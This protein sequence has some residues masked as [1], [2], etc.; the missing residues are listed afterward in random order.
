MLSGVK[1]RNNE[2]RGNIICTSELN[3]NAHTQNINN[4]IRI[5]VIKKCLSGFF[6]WGFYEIQLLYC[7][8]MWNESQF[9]FD[10]PE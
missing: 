8:N 2:R 7:N 9:V 6:L 1:E 3:A 4:H 5:F 10:L